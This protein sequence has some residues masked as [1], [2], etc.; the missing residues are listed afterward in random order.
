MQRLPIPGRVHTI[1]SWRIK[2]DPHDALKQSFLRVQAVHFKIKSQQLS[3]F[4]S[5]ILRSRE[6]DSCLACVFAERLSNPRQEA[7]L[8]Y[9]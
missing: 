4:I 1:R 3:K 9:W 6:I 2:F 7:Q 5:I 8:I